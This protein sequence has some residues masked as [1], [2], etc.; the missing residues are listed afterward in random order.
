MSDHAALKKCLSSNAQYPA[1]VVLADVETLKPRAR[2]PRTHSKKQ[3]DQIAASI[4]RFGFVNPILVDKNNRIIA[5][6]GRVEGAKLAGL[7]LVPTLLVSHLSEDEI[8]AYVI[9]D[10]KLAENAG[11]DQQLLALELKE[12]SIELDFEITLTGFETPEIDLLIKTLSGEP[13]PE[14][15][16]PAVDKAVPA[17][18][19]PGDLWLIGNH[20]LLCGDARDSEAYARLMSGE[21]AG[22]VFT[23][24]PWNLAING[25]VSGLGKVQHR[26]FAMASGE[27]TAQEFAHFLRQVLTNLTANSR[28]GSLHFICMDWRHMPDLLQ[29]AQP[30]YAEFKNLCVW[31]KTNAGMGSLYRS[32]HELVFVYKNGTAAH[33]NNVELGKHGRNRSNVWEYA[34]ANAFGKSRDADLAMHPTVKPLTM[35]ADAILDVSN[36]GDIILDCFS[37]SGTTLLAAQD[38]GRRGFGMEIDPHYVDLIIARFKQAHDLPARCA[39]TGSSWED[40]GRERG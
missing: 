2:N 8:R 6:H 16:V 32:Q 22:A 7:K 24:P 25:H 33:I 14:P 29:A 31:V 3:L 5:G 18:T 27:M 1:G 17:V 30:V 12:L 39:A 34:G 40:L 37:G 19:R 9:A 13:P 21:L 35:V 38:T 36:R 10:N 28:D 15:L 4:K 20:R 11:W 23:D 26:E